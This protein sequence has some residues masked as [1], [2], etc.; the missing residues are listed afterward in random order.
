MKNSDFYNIDLCASIIYDFVQK[1]K[2]TYNKDISFE[3]NVNNFKLIIE[4]MPP[5]INGLYML[6]GDVLNDNEEL[7]VS[8]I[9]NIL[10]IKL[11]TYS[12]TYIMNLAINEVFKEF[13]TNIDNIKKITNE[14]N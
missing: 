5:A 11:E 6:L 3:D 7:T 10:L 2:N 13:K 9:K 4:S 12:D 14:N 1:F 8:D